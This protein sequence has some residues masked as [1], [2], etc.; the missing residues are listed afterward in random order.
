ML[1]VHLGRLLAGIRA[2]HAARIL[3]EAALERDGCGKEQ[4]VERRAVESL[5]DKR[6]VATTK[7][8]CGLDDGVDQAAARRNLLDGS[9]WSDARQIQSLDEGDLAGV[10]LSQGTALLGEPRL[11]ITALGDGAQVGEQRDSRV[12]VVRLARG[13]QRIDL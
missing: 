11:A 8:W 7:K 2:Q 13:N 10:R 4:R 5:A 12:V 6:P 1:V 3:H 9:F